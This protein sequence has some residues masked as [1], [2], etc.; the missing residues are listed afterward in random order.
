[1]PGHV[2][3]D[4][5]LT[6]DPEMP[7]SEAGDILLDVKT[8]LRRHFSDLEDILVQIEPHVEE[9]VDDVPEQLI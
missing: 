8:T 6:L 7:L 9:H 4:L 1:M 2:H 5:H 3:L